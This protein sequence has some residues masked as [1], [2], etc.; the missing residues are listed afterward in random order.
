MIFFLFIS[1]PEL[2]ALVNQIYSM[3]ENE[4]EAPLSCIHQLQR[5]CSIDT[6]NNNII[7]DVLIEANKV[8]KQLREFIATSKL[9]DK[10]NRKLEAIVNKLEILIH[11]LLVSILL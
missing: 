7:D 8:I 9:D 4:P 6:G 2:R 10:K 5:F 11:H 1:E 3:L